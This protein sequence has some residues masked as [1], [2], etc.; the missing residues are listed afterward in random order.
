MIKNEKISTFEVM[1]ETKF[2]S[3]ISCQTY[4]FLAQLAEHET[5]DLEGVG[6]NNTVGNFLWNLFF[7]V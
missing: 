1:H 2:T 3:E 6:S 7:S 4:S 5:D